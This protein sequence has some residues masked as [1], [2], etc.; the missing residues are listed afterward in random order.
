MSED[1]AET[2]EWVLEPETEYRFELDPGTSLAVKAGPRQCFSR[3]SL[4]AQGIQ[5]SRGHAEIFGF[6]LVEGQTYVFGAECALCGASAGM[7]SLAILPYWDVLT[8]W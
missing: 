5:L 4:T 7:T 8:S 3:I 6:E 2:K 1:T